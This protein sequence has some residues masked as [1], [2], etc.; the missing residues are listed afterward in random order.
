M[1]TNN[2]KF[3]I[4]HVGSAKLKDCARDGHEVIHTNAYRVLQ[5]L[6]GVE[7]QADCHDC[8]HL[9]DEVPI[10]FKLGNV[11]VATEFSGKQVSTTVELGVGR[12]PRGVDS[13]EFDRQAVKIELTK[14]DFKRI[15]AALDEAEAAMAPFTNKR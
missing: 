14:A 10:L 1:N 12:A 6:E 7:F 2:T 15:R 8:M 11:T 5:R 3:K 9:A 13:A 4:K